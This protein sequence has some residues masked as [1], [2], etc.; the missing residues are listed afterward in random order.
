M[1]STQKIYDLQSLNFLRSVS[2]LRSGCLSGNNIHLK[3]TALKIGILGGSF[4]PAHPG[5]LSISM[6]ALSR[7]GMDYVLWIVAKQNP[8][9]PRYQ[10]D[11]YTRARKASKVATD[12]R[13]LVSTIEE[14]FGSIYIYNTMQSILKHF[15]YV[16]FTWLMGIDN[17]IG[18]NQWYMHDEFTKL[19]KIIIFDRDCRVRFANDGLFM[20]KYK[21]VIDNSQTYPIIS[22]RGRLSSDSSSAIRCGR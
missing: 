22:F 18:F 9:K 1:E 5:H 20:S 4:N 10:D 17:L 12:K 14:E 6:Q 15:P 3:S 11:I 7:F 16:D 8:L 21:P 2:R 19:C 13:I